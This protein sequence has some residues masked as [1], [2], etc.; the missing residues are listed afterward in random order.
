MI[1]QSESISEVIS[2]KNLTVCQFFLFSSLTKS[3]LD[4]L[5]AVN[6]DNAD[7]KEV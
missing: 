4:I 7:K 6:I 1:N 2:I 5:K 3:A